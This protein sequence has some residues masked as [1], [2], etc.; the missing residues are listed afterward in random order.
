MVHAVVKDEVADALGRL[1]TLL[2]LTG[3]RESRRVLLHEVRLEMGEQ[4][5]TLEVIEG[6][7]DETEAVTAQGALV[8]HRFASFFGLGNIHGAAV[9]LEIGLLHELF[10]ARSATAPSL[11]SETLGIVV[12][13][14]NS[15]I[16][17]RARGVG[18]VCLVIRATLT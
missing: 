15:S 5:V 12:Q 4:S 13:V 8:G 11:V 18:D 14:G 6:F 1:F 2:N 16:L 3:L 10:G 7:V 9:E 17:D